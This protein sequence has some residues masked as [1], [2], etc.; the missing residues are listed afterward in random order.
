[1]AKSQSDS[2]RVRQD[3]PESIISGARIFSHYCGISLLSKA[4]VRSNF[5]LDLHVLCA[6]LEVVRFTAM[7]S[8]R[9]LNADA[10][11]L[12]AN[13]PDCL[14]LD[15]NLPPNLRE[16]LGFHCEPL[17]FSCSSTRSSCSAYLETC[18]R[19]LSQPSSKVALFN[20]GI[21]AME[22]HCSVISALERRP[23]LRW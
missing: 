9:P 11:K 19:P 12:C 15:I 14:R 13:F 22:T 8:A 10:A 6:H 21:R 1:M 5:W 17:C 2:S 23:L 7:G 3:Q 18:G 20:Q 16:V 4:H